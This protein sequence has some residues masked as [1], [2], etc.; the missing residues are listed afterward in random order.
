M[1][2][3]FYP[4]CLPGEPLE[5]HEHK[6]MTVHQWLKENVR[7]YRLDIPAPITVE[8][9]GQYIPAE[10]WP[11]CHIAPSTSVNIR[12]IPYGGVIGGL[13]QVI[14]KPLQLVFNLLGFRMAVDGGLSS[15]PAG[16]SLE[17]S[18]ARANTAKLGD[19]IREVLGI[20]RIYPDYAVQPVARFDPGNPQVYRSNMFLVVGAGNYTFNPSLLKVGNTP[21]SAFGDDISYTIYPPGADVSG[22]QRSEN[23]CAAPEV[24]GT[25][26]GT[27]GLDLASTGPASVSVTADAV[28]VSGNNLTV[29]SSIPEAIPESWQAGTII[30]ILAPDA[31]NVGNTGDGNV[32][33]G[34][35]TELNPFVGLPVSLTFNGQRFDLFVSAY[36]PG[37]PAVPGVGGNAASI[38]ASAAP[39]TYDFSTSPVTFTLSW[40]GVPYV[41][42]LSANYI[43]MAGLIDEITDQLVGSDLVA[44]SDAGR[45]VIRE[46]ESPFTGNSITYS[47][48]PVS[49]FGTS[50]AIIAGAASTGGLPA[51]IPSIRLAVGSAVGTPFA[52][53]PVGQQRLSLGLTGYQYRI[54]DINGSTLTVERLI[55]GTGG[56]VTV[57]ASWTG[58]TDRTL[59]DFTVTGLNEND[60]WMGPFLSCPANEVTNLIELN[61]VY[62]Q[63]LCDV[64]SKDG[65][66]HWHEV[67]MTVQYRES[68]SVTWSSVQIIHGNQTVNEV[69]YTER[70]ALPTLATYE[71]RIKRDTPVWGGTTRDAVQWQSM[72]ARLQSR[73][74]R[75]D[76]V[77]TM[78]VTIR[79]GPRLAA[80]S[81]RR[82]NVVGARVYD[83]YPARS[84]SGALFHV[85]KSLGFSDSQI[86]YATINA[87]EEAYWTPRGE[88]FDYSADKSD[89]SALEVLQKITNAGMGY[90]LLS[91]GMASAGREGIKPWVGVIS[92]QEQTEELTTGFTAHSQDD[93]DGVD[94][95]YRNGATWAEE[96]VQCR[97][98]DNP[99]PAKVENYKLEGVLDQDRAYRI[100][101]RRLMG[102]KYQRLTHTTSTELDAL[103]YEYMDRIIMTDDIPGSTISCLI[104]GMSYTPSLITLEVS[105][106]L[107][108][109]LENPRVLIRFQDG[110]ASGLL[111]PTRVDDYTLTVPYSSSISVEDWEMDS[112]T[113]EPPRLIFCSSSRIGHDT[114]LAEIVPNNDG[115]CQVS[116]VQYTPLKYQYDDAVYPGDVQ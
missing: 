22:D 4:S 49:L 50:P 31:Y 99:T 116:A 39:T 20:S 82:V 33:Y 55:Q 21:F 71:I 77:T 80:Q 69:G 70:I 76:G 94:V 59:L 11:L 114:M 81:D 57:D 111:V 115:T 41:I 25:T 73:P 10:E 29:M 106:P 86:D 108:W 3:R 109:T 2:I 30:T 8:I 32:F 40:A 103:C 34:D 83:G 66:I 90:F 53:I 61:F 9:D 107:D 5:T 24:G 1:T 63:G 15:P 7:E 113:R 38:T 74:T 19:P 35:F 67:A 64:G 13:L 27:A 78:A 46:F 12:P 37:A 96:T 36:N 54:T 104:V 42:S 62:P 110:G 79:T 75:Y 102:Y 51:V 95:T 23:W 101:M 91:D 89:I 112:G 92:P 18:G 85:L 88:T 100:G 97:A 6:A 45:L 14:T 72:M 58:F 52:G 98:A 105:E 43:T 60:D 65:A 84:I 16:T 48:L 44:D 56:V 47:L 28:M 93:F 87:I 17:L 68:G 26:S